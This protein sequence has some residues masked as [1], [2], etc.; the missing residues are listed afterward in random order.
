MEKQW[1]TY[2]ENDLGV[3]Y[4]SEKTIFR[5][6]APTAEHVKICLYK[7]GDGDCLITAADMTKSNGGTWIFERRG[8]FAGV[9]YTYLVT[10]DGVTRET[11]DPYAVAAGVNGRRSMVVDLL[12]T[13]PDGF[14]D[15]KR[16]KL[17]APTDAI[18]CEISV[19]D[20]TNDATSGVRHKGKFLGLAE[21]GTKSPLGLPT[22]LDYLEWLGVTHVQI[23][24]SYDFGCID[25]ADTSADQYNWGYD[26]V[27]Y[28]VPEGSYS[29][30]PFH[31]EV[32]IR[33]MKTMIQALHAKGIGVIM[34]VVYNHTYDIEGSC[35]Q[36]TAPDYFYR[37]TETGYSNA[38]DCGNE[39]ASERPM[40]R[41]YIVDSLK[42]WMTEYH[43][44]GFRF[45]L[46]GVLDLETM[47]TI[48]DEL[49]KLRPDVLLYGEGWTGGASTLPDDKRALKTNISKL[50]GIGA[51]SDD[52]RDSARGHVF[53]HLE[54][55]FINGKEHYEND[56][57]YSVAG[58]TMHPQVD[59]G[60]YTYTTTGP[61]AANPAQVIN[62]VS[63]HDNLTLW[64]KLL[65]TCPNA[66]EKELLAMNRLGA[67]IVFASQGIPF[68]L[69]GEEFGR[70]KPI[71]GSDELSENS[72]NMPKF[73]NNI[74][75]DAAYAHRALIDYYRG[76]IAF[77]KAHPALRLENAEQMRMQLHFDNTTPDNV[78]AFWI[79]T[80]EET[81]YV[82]LNANWETKKA[83]LPL[84]GRFQVYVSGEKAG[85]DILYSAAENIEILPKSAVFAVQPNRE[86]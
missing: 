20:I 9:Y 18:I 42:Y 37:R 57:R 81:V 31:G 79:E 1:E 68:F 16:P 13:N 40:V 21:K 32:R 60:A 35:F 86:A 22:G 34:D 43:I 39:V 73:T 8:D 84:D 5:L 75:Y 3:T 72:Y 61:W 48:S 67:S 58:A 83:A 52:I 69:S 7:E 11:V 29:T 65:I 54:T 53:Y 15:E 63:C 66:T 59:Y 25:E 26:P 41:K 64:D 82:A 19:A 23:M 28:N 12:E 62:Y 33:E 74:R 14:M 38:S 85:C 36:K 2:L 30:D 47:Q 80:P 71:E 27:N 24:P 46:M 51:F 4:T 49:H 10:I 70:T 78:V 56:I 6:W 17:K 44:D 45:D 55:G 76:L 77:R 50:K